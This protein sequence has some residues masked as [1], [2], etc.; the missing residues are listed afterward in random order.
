MNG[1]VFPYQNENPNEMWNS[2]KH[3]LMSVID[4]HAP[5]KTKRIRNNR[6]PWITNELVGEIHKRDFLKK[7]A[8][9]TNNPL[10]W[11]EFKDARNKVNNSIKK[12]KREYFSEKLDASKCDTRKTWRLINELQPRQCKSTK[13][14]QIKSG[15][16]VF[17]SP[18]DI[19]E[20][21]NNHFT[22]IGQTL[23]REIP[24]IDTDPLYYVKPSDRV[25]S[26]E[27][28]NVQEVVN[29]VKG[30]DGGKATG[31]DNNPCKLLK[32]A[33]DVAAPSLTCI[34]NQSLL[35]GI[36]PSDWKLA[37]VTPIFK[38][39]SKTDLNNYRPISVI[40]AVAKIFEKII[41]D[42]LYNYLNVNDLLTSC[43]SGFRSL[44]STLTA[45]LETSNNWCVNVGKGLRNG[46]IFIDLKKAF[47][48]TDHEIIL[49]KLAK[50][51]VDQDALKWFKS[52]LANCLQRC[53]VNNH[54]SSTSLLN[55][56]V[57]QGSII[58]RTSTFFY[59][60]K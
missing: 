35:T 32:I 52:Y 34:F 57:P 42:Q 53:N 9:S 22:S 50:Y 1:T 47:D 41:Y 26:F 37:K 7:K 40:P 60:Y 4:K 10:I 38:N 29:L 17:T 13:V 51:G 15:H 5:L 43:Q 2:W 45:L 28:I 8:T 49:Q 14:S 48:T 16:Q 24:T 20:A 54:L 58:G 56:G 18:E 23:A 31:L 12:A 25:F 44:H 30:I 33:A 46:V 21:F 27:R 11:K 3:L 19:A 6:S 39:G 59:L 55:C 36:Y